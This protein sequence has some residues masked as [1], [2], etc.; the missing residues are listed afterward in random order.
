MRALGKSWQ[1]AILTAG[2]LSQIGEFS[3]LLA[4]VGL[5]GGILDHGLHKLLVLVIALTL[6]LSPFWVIMVKRLATKEGIK[7]PD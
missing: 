4:T 3:F 2:L 6:L 1:M 5:H 7:L